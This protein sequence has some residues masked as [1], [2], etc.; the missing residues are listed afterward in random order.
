MAKMIKCPT[1]GTQIEV[2]AQASGQIVKCPGCGKGLKLVA[3]PKPGG[4]GAGGGSP[5]AGAGV[6]GHPGGSVA[7][8]SVS[9]MTY[10]GDAPPLDPPASAFDDMPSLDSN[11]AVCGRATDPDEL[12]EDNGRLVCGD[13]IKGARSAIARPEGGADLIDFKPAAGPIRRGKLI[14]FTPSFFAGLLAALIFV[15]CT[16][17]LHLELVKKPV[18]TQIALGGTTAGG[19]NGAAG[20][21]VTP[22]PDND[23][24]PPPATSGTNTATSTTPAASGDNDVATSAPANNGASTDPN[25]VAGAPAT[26]TTPATPPDSTNPAAT[27]PPGNGATGATNPA[28]TLA[29]PG[30]STIFS[31]GGGADAA[32]D[33]SGTAAAPGAGAAPDAG[34]AAVTPPVAPLPS[35]V[36]NDPLERGMERLVA[37]DFPKAVPDLIEAR[38]KYVIG[39][40]IKGARFTPQQQLALEALAA[41]Y[42][43]QKRYDS[44]RGP[45]EAA[46]LNNVRSR[47]LTLNLAIYSLNT[48]RS[49]A[50]LI[51]VAEMVRQYMGAN[52]NDEYAADIFGTLVNKVAGTEKPPKEKI[53]LWWGFHD[54][55]IDQMAARGDVGQP[56]KLKWGIDWMPAEQV[57]GFRA[58]R[59]V[60]NGGGGVGAAAKEVELAALRVR[61]A[62]IALKNAKAARASGNSADVTGAETQLATANAGLVKAQKALNDANNAVNVKQARW[63]TNFDPVIPQQAVAP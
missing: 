50:D 7:G 6:G 9:A 8:S 18:G 51:K 54:N 11:C 29:N 59:A 23:P 32:K 15:V 1:C 31:D 48:N 55:Y 30:E 41:A 53:D 4:G 39:Q 60:G 44:A 52:Q 13:C 58:A 62:E 46:Y 10:V 35:V 61:S 25:A 20:A 2:P 56:G 27:T 19:R 57:Q 36:S 22:D 28:V 49:Q 14:N 42:I 21:G 43:G 17:V 45:L 5:H 34:A 16:L 26:P 37:R 47:S 63:L 3:K 38:R 40:V 12:V 24:T 33:A